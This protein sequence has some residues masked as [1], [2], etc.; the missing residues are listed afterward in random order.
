MSTTQ[1]QVMVG[2]YEDKVQAKK[3]IDDLR[4][5]G[6]GDDQ[7]RMITRE[8]GLADQCLLNTLVYQGISEEDVNYY[9]KE[10]EAGHPLVLVWYSGCKE[11]MI[12]FLLSNCGPEQL[13]VSI[14]GITVTDSTS[15]KTH[16]IEKEN[17]ASSEEP[18][19]WKLLKDA[20]LD[21]LLD[22]LN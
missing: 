21:H 15:P 3:A 22:Q 12:D 14:T 4:G 17:Q 18:D 1:H 7:I 19:W 20:K 13:N 16:S 5:I 11:D 2:A 10:F 9:K 8:G 6:I